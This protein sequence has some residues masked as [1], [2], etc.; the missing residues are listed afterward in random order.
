MTTTIKPKISVI[1]PTCYRY[2]Y[3]YSLL[4]QF[5]MQTM[6]PYE[7]FVID[8]TPKKDRKDDIESRYKGKL[9]I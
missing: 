4:D 6:S 2:D 8:G 1:I 7:L 5:S 3:L 9:P